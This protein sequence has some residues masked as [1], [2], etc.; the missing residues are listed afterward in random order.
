[1]GVIDGVAAAVFA[2]ATPDRQPILW[3]HPWWSG[4][5]PY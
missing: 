4:R 2:A 5:P 3:I 1:M